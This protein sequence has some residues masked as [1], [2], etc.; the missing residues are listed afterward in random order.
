MQLSKPFKSTY[1]NFN[2]QMLSA[3]THAF[4]LGLAVVGTVALAFKATTTLRLVTFLGFGFSL[5]ILYLGS[6]LFHGF[7]FTKARHVLQVIDHSSVF[8]LIA[9][10]YLPYC[11]VAIGGP[12]GWGLLAA[13]WLLCAAGIA[14]KLFFLG[15]FRGAETAIYV[16]LGWMCLIGMQPLW[17]HLGRIGFWLLVAGGVA[18]TVGA[19]LYSQ[20]KI[21]YIHVV[22]H[23]FVMIGSACMYASIYL[24]V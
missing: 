8:I 24:F 12:L 5:I 1:Y 19:L 21:P 6:T 18:Y 13:I 20:K 11:L 16:I 17:A 4:A 3:V 23:V 9:G 15:R 2:D 7:Y 10:S 14:Y 22:W